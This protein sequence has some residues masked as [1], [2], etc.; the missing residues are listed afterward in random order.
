MI[1]T[2]EYLNSRFDH[3]NDMCFEGKLPKVTIELATSKH[4][5]GKFA[6]RQ[7]RLTRRYS[8][9]KIKI[10]RRLDCDEAL[11]DDTLIH[12]MIHYY[13]FVSRIKDTSAHGQAF[14]SIMNVINQKYGRHISI[15]HKSGA[16]DSVFISETRKKMR[17]VAVVSFSDG[18]CGVKLV[19]M[20]EDR[21]NAFHA[22]IKR[23]AD[24]VSVS[25]YLSDDSYFCQFPCSTALRF[26]IVAKADVT[27]HLSDA[28]Q[29]CL[30]HK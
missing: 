4:F 5:L 14:V 10:N 6:Y 15:S 25:Y 26:C 18:R 29:V 1:P 21:L 22:R 24:I 12:E 8:D 30:Q 7:N 11:I 17:L 23:I 3:Y 2:L 13:I 27:T 20:A 9:V 28:K 16:E 19:P